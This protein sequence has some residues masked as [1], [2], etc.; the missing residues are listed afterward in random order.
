MKK[1]IF[2]IL[3]FFISINILSQTITKNSLANYDSLAKE[4]VKT[5]LV[6]GQGYKW[7][8]Q[9]CE[10]GPRLSGS[11][12]YEDALNW[13]KKTFR[14][15]GVDSVYLQECMVPHWVRGG[16]EE[17]ILLDQHGIPYKQ[18][19]ITAL[20]GSD[21]TNGKEI[22]EKIVMFDSF[23][24][25]KAR[26]QDAEGNIVFFNNKFDQSLLNTF[27]GY[28][29][30]VQYRVFGAIEAAKAGAKAV[31]IRSVSSSNDNVPHT[32]V[33]R[34]IDSVKHIPAA[35]I[36][37]RD[38]N[39]L[40]QLF[41]E[42]K[43]LQLSLNLSCENLPDTE[44][45]NIIAEIRGSELPN[46]IV[47]FGGHFDSWDVG[48]GAHDDGAPCI[49]TM[50]VLSLV[51]RMNITPKRT[52]RCVLFAN[53][54]NGLRGAIKYGQIADSL[55]EFHLAAIESDRGGFTPR[56]FTTNAD[57]SVMAKL[58]T[59]LPV[60]NNAQIEWIK[61]GGTGGD[62]A[63]IKNAKALFGYVPD[64][65]RYMDFHHS[66]ND[67]FEGVNPREMELGSAAITILSL[68]LSEEGL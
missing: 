50:E 9:L 24:D 16:I 15:I 17:A 12:G 33:M 48:C 27:A 67:V 4:I 40:E 31:L 21:G 59:W 65:Q 45:W 19:A 34:Y 30:G 10:I 54:E 26:P 36:G 47:A 46:E 61:N 38:A 20:G 60:L 7:L 68:L 51:R 56:G 29:K 52:L 66:A 62:V 55:K 43:N 1:A 49:Q 64:S 44:G 39:Y 8:E 42:G 28:S 25:L 58:Q 53:E 35:A 32:G 37:V 22:R 6:E 23:D 13:A 14:Q 3:P 18:I 11:A 41:K 5:A 63:Q 2:L 57:S